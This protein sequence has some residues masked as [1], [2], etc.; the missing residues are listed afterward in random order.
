MERKPM[1]N[2]EGL[3]KTLLIHLV[4]DRSCPESEW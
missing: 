2:L 1:N 3:A 4:I